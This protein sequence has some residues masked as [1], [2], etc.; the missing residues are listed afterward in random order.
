[1]AEPWLTV[2]CI[3][4]NAKLIKNIEQSL[5]VE[6]EKDVKLQVQISEISLREIREMGF[7]YIISSPT[8]IVNT[9]VKQQLIFKRKRK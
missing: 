7:N 1:M 6:M 2:L 4:Y 5:T 3:K 9:F 8:T